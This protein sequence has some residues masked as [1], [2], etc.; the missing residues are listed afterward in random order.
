MAGHHPSDATTRMQ[1]IAGGEDHQAWHIAITLRQNGL[2][3]LPLALE[4][5]R[6]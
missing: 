4:T 3:I 1:A 5:D 2:D 6:G